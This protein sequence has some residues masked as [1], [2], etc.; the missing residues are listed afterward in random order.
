MHVDW[1]T[2]TLC[3]SVRA[4]FPAEMFS[5]TLSAEGQLC[6]RFISGQRIHTKTHLLKTL[7]PIN[8]SLSFFFLRVFLLI[9]SDHLRHRWL[10]VSC[11][12]MKYH[13]SSRY[14]RVMHVS[15]QNTRLFLLRLDVHVFWWACSTW[16]VV[17]WHVKLFL[18]MSHHTLERAEVLPQFWFLCSTSF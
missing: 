4:R 10:G 5:N 7:S 11:A 8:I 15:Q 16:C 13:T 3:R 14:D 18:Y 9:C 2:H 1:C 12:N 17:E 6:W